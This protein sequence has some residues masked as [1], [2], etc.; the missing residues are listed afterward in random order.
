[1]GVA[2]DTGKTYPCGV[3]EYKSTRAG[4]RPPLTVGGLRPIK[5][6]KFLW[7]TA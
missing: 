6:S 1:M 7:A 2:T 4:G 5:L 3:L